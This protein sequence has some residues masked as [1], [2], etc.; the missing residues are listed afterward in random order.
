MATPHLAPPVAF[1][2]GDDTDELAER[3]AA[4]G[5]LAR[6]RIAGHTHWALTSHEA[7]QE[8]LHPRSDLFVRSATYRDHHG[9]FDASSPLIANIRV[10]SMLTQ[11][12][13]DHRR[14]R[15]LVQNVFTRRRVQELRPQ[16][17]AITERLLERIAEP[18]APRPVDLKQSLAMP[19]PIQVIGRLLGLDPDDY[20]AISDI[21]ERTLSGVDTAVVEEAYRFIGDLVRRKRENPDDALISAMIAENS[22]DGDKLG[23]E[24]L[25][26]TVYLLLIAGFETTMGALANGWR[27]LLR[28]PDQLGLL[29]GGTV[30]WEQ[31]IEEVLRHSTS[32]NLLPAIFPTREVSYG[33]VT[34]PQ[35]TP[36]LLAYKAAGRDRK[37]W[38]DAASFDVTRERTPNLAFGYGAHRC[39]GEHLARLEL[40]VALPALFERFPGLRSA[41]DD[42]PAPSLLM[43]HPR[44]LLVYP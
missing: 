7:L 20:P 4:T 8:A 27:Q 24:E 5:P 22:A 43:S 15:G 18:G 34:L 44:R 12:G 33:G 31:G 23:A 29:T 28:H 30:T 26:D 19:V 41:E 35:G 6:L 1:D 38:H 3:L 11:D 37:V 32:V 13:P 40:G 21:A 36:V 39:L 10:R 16:V 14:V 9:E 42:E 25:A 2:P 17:E